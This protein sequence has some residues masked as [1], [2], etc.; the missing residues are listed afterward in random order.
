QVP[1]TLIR[2]GERMSVELPVSPRHEMLIESLHGRYPRYF[3]F[4]PLVF[5]PVTTE[6]L[7]G[8]ERFGSVFSVIGSPLATRRGDRVRFEGEELV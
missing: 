6:F 3:V 5:A 8:F 2:D 1:L 4:G 7:S